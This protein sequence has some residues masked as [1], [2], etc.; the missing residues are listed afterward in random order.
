MKPKRISWLGMTSVGFAETSAR[1][2][3]ALFVFFGG[4]QAAGTCGIIKIDVCTYRTICTLLGAS[5]AAYFA[6][7]VGVATGGTFLGTTRS[8]AL[9]PE[10]AVL[11]EAELDPA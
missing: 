6:Y 4:F 8:L 2:A 5:V 7:L 3:I 1:P 10:D 11:F 9:L